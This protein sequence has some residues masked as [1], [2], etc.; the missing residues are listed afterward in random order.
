MPVW[1]WVLIGLGAA[2]VVGGGG[3][4]A[5]TRVGKQE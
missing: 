2:A 4:L 1:A 5:F 3:Y